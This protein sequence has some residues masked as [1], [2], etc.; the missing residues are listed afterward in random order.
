M[1]EDQVARPRWYA[2]RV[3]ARRPSIGMCHRLGALAGPVRVPAVDAAGARSV[4]EAPVMP[5]RAEY[6]VEAVL[7]RRGIEA[8][9][10]VESVWAR[11]NRYHRRARQLVLHPMLTGYVLVRMAPGA[12][13][14][15]VLACPLVAGVVGTHGVPMAL[16]DAAVARL[17]E[18][19]C[20]LQADAQ[21]RL[22][23]TRR[24]YRVGD[25]VEVLDGPLEGT[26]M[27]VVAIAG[28]L[29]RVVG[30]LFGGEV[31]AEIA[32]DRIGAV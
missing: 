23:P 28:D 20:H 17:R 14:E 11:A 19:Q 25:D 15:P 12:R 1:I 2:L 32:V 4:P 3:V 10:P 8:W 21:S 24:V 27:R 30:P 9:V 29:A 6:V 22:M 13:W 31:E 26:V 18:A 5:L 7:G 16:P